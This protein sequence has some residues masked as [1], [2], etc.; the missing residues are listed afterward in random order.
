MEFYQRKRELILLTLSS[1]LILLVALPACGT[2][3]SGNSSSGTLTPESFTQDVAPIFNQ[4]CIK[5]HGDGQLNGGLDLT[6]YATLM[7]GGKKGAV[8]IPGN[9]DGSLLVQYIRQGLMPKSSAK[10]TQGQI[11]IIENWV[12][13]G[14]Q[15]N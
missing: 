15:D 2:S 10:L 14:A 13:G 5:C 8:I 9:A 11:S 4:R 6:S 12:N 1:L 7:R 3:G